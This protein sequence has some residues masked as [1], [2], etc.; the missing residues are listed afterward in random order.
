MTSWTDSDLKAATSRA[1]CFSDVL[2]EINV[3]LSGNT[4]ALVKKRMREIQVDTS[5]FDV[6]AVRRR[7]TEKKREAT[8]VNIFC[9]MSNVSQGTVRRAAKRVILPHACSECSNDGFHN[10]KVLKLQLDHRNG[11]R[12][13]NRYENLRWLCPNCHSQTDTYSR[14][15]KPFLRRVAAKTVTLECDYCKEPFQRKTARVEYTKTWNQKRNFCGLPCAHLAQENN[16]RVDH[17]KVVERYDKLG[18][19]NAVAK[20]MGVSFQAISKIL[21]KRP[22]RLPEGPQPLE[23]MKVSS[24]LPGVTGGA[25]D[26][27]IRKSPPTKCNVSCSGRRT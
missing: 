4:M 1:L 8:V 19:K 21:K 2:R 10:G 9:E 17:D 22:R 14:V 11:I 16:R 20:E 3:V 15:K 26:A 25:P 24:T 23:L 6:K 12:N 13:D 7:A 5:H 18:S 27:C